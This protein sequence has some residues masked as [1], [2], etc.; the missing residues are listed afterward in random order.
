MKVKSIFVTSLCCFALL[1]C[2]Q[3]QQ[4]QTASGDYPLMTLT[5]E[6][7]QLSVKYS[8]VIEGKQDVEVRPQVSGTITQVLVKEGAHR[9]QGPGIVHHRPGSL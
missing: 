6:D 4:Q 5:P 7:R 9:T 8:A 3:N 2:Q 1:S